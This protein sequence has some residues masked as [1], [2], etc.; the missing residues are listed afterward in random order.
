M[1]AH[2]DVAAAEQALVRRAARLNGWQQLQSELPMAVFGISGNFFPS[3][4]SS[5]MSAAAPGGLPR[6][7]RVA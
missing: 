5:R 4:G 2:G 7:A 6:R 3:G 1:K